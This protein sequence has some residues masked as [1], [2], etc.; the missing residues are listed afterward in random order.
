MNKERRGFD[1]GPL[2]EEN[3]LFVQQIIGF[4]EDGLQFTFE[5]T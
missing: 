3:A 2:G 4:S 1:F 5:L